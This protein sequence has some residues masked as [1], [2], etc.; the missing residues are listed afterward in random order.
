METGTAGPMASSLRAQ[1]DLGLIIVGYALRESARRKVL[2]VVGVLTLAFLVLYALGCHFAFKEVDDSFSSTG[3]PGDIDDRALAGAT[4][5]GLAMFAI[6]FLGAVLGT[7][8]TIGIV[9]G[10]AETGLL[11]PLVAR[12]V[13]RTTILAAR[14]A[15]ASIVAVSYVVA[16]FVIAML[17]T[18][19]TGDWTPDRVFPALFQLAAAV[20]VVV[21]LSVLASVFTASTAQGITVLM[22]FGAGLTAGL[23][24]QIGDALDSDTLIDISEIT[25]WALPFEALYQ[26]GLYALTADTSGVTGFLLSL[27][28]F[29]GA[30]DSG[31]FLN[32]FALAWVALAIG[33]AGWFF[34]RRDL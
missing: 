29:G 6:L 24:G 19:I 13:E 11:Q 7:F 10:D 33:A 31:I 17:I 25:S 14:A 2:L 21:S 23:L 34:A 22:L 30:R 1:F 15:G 18:W 20:V 28:P 32:F 16:V 27:G 5:L 3:F 12:P 4:L 9:R 8:L 26:D